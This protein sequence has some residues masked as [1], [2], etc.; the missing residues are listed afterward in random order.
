MKPRFNLTLLIF[1]AGAIVITIALL[2]AIPAAQ[3]PGTFDAA[4]AYSLVNDQMALGPRIPGSTA[5]QQV[6]TWMVNALNQAGWSTSITNDSAMGHPVQNVVAKKGSGSP[7]II[8]GAHY[9]SRMKADQDPDI[10]NRTQP[11]PGA[12]DG[13]SGVAVL[14]ELA[15]VLSIKQGQV[16]LAF[17]DAEDQGD[18]PGWDWLLGSQ[19]LADQLTGTP[20]AVVIIDMIGDKNLNIY[21]E[22]SSTPVLVDQIW[23]AAQKAGHGDVFLPQA[24]YRMLD[25]HTPFLNKGLDAADLIDFDYPYW[26]TTADT[27]DKVAGDSLKAVGDT[28]IEWLSTR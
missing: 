22:S 4:S 23:S 24:K 13:A 26:H 2:I 16:W 6:I 9:D 7:W 19:V 27:A 5:H 21:K 25:D 18:L 10:A 1:T 12:D 20:D 17:F 8:L 3:R 14:L 28:L 15:R 11:V